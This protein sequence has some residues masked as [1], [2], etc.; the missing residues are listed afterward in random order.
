MQTGTIA[1]ALM[2]ATLMIA[3]VPVAQ[4]HPGAENAGPVWFMNQ[5]HRDLLVVETNGLATNGMQSY[6]GAFVGDTGVQIHHGCVVPGLAIGPGGGYDAIYTGDVFYNYIIG[7]R[8]TAGADDARQVTEALDLW[9]A[10]NDPVVPLNAF[11]GPDWSAYDFG[12]ACT[13][14]GGDFHEPDL[15][16]FTDENLGG[17]MVQNLLGLPPHEL[18]DLFPPSDVIGGQI[19]PPP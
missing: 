14:R 18:V 5:H 7:Q 17:A 11:G 8:I 10:Q 9:R 4:A 12:A 3:L 15:L 2:A 6:H 13:A 19:P 16:L 1:A